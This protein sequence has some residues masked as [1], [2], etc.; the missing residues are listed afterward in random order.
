MHMHFISQH[1]SFLIICLTLVDLRRHYKLLTFY[2]YVTVYVI[3]PTLQVTRSL[4]D[5]V[6]VWHGEYISS[7]EMLEY[8]CSCSYVGD[9][10]LTR[11]RPG[12]GIV[13]FH[14]PEVITESRCLR[15]LCMCSTGPTDGTAWH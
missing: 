15:V 1:F 2:Y 11:N 7:V 8:C 13:I 3:K 6:I 10:C 5:A 14:S 12:I 4:V 9:R